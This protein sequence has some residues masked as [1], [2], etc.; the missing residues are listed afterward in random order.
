MVSIGPSAKM[1]F[2]SPVF[3]FL[4]LPIVLSLY[5]VFPDKAKNNLLL[6]ASLIFYAWGEVYYVLLMLFSILINYGF[7]LAV[8]SIKQD[9]SRK[10]ALGVAISSNLLILISLKYANF[11]TDN[12]NI[13]LSEFS[14][15]TINL[16]QIPLPIGI[17]F[18]TFQAMSYVID[19]YRKEAKVQKNIFDLALYISLFP[20]LIAGPIVRFHD[21]AEQIRHRIVSASLFFSGTQR[22]I[23]GLAKKMLIAN[24]LGEVADQI[25][26]LA[27]DELSMGVAWLGISCYTLQI[28]FD[29]SGYSDMA[30]GLGRMFGFRF[31][32]NFNY[33]YI[34]KSI[35]EFWRR[36]H[37]SLSSWFRDYLYIP[38]GGNRKGSIRTY[39]NLLTVFFLCGLWHGSSWNF[40]IWGLYHGSFLML[41][42]MGLG[43][44]ISQQ[45]KPLQY[46]Y[47]LLAVMI[48]WVFFRAETLSGASTFLQ[49]MFVPMESTSVY[50]VTYYLSGHVLVCLIFGIVLATPFWPTINKKWIN[51]LRLPDAKPSLSLTIGHNMATTVYLSFLTL[52]CFAS[53]AANSY[54]PFIYFRF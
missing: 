39:F 40:I 6:V 17:S 5:Y 34:S 21:V 15:K 23:Y 28:Y 31:L 9:K 41:E 14:F 2:S 18:F 8:E 44:F 35:Q 1:L 26:S 46:L 10:I 13:L 11:I 48:G 52:C 38:L 20:Q 42:R 19:V 30:I 27:P 12:I 29:F 4:F 45:A 16:A 53:I 33:P 22:F 51:Q 7:G 47:A 49:A 37:I 32:E 36:W 54:D 50:S 24:P 25:F 43:G 3:L